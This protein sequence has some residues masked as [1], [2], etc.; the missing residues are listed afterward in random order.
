MNTT[1]QFTS[2]TLELF[3]K[4]GWAMVKHVEDVIDRDDRVEINRVLE[5]RSKRL[6]DRKNCVECPKSHK[7]YGCVCPRHYHDYMVCDDDGCWTC[8]VARVLTEQLGID[9]DF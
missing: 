4:H 5:L 1:K 7:E 2:R 3:R 8:Y 9:T 6:Q